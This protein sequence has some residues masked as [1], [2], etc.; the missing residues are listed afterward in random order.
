MDTSPETSRALPA[1]IATAAPPL[2]PPGPPGSMRACVIRRTG[3]REHGMCVNYQV[4]GEHRPGTMA[5]YVVV[6]EQNVARIPRLDPPL[7]WAEAAAFSLA[8][9]TAWRMVVTRARVRAEEWVLV[10]GVGGGVSLAAMQI[11]KLR[12]ARLIVTSASD[13]KLAEARKLGA[14]VTLN[15]RTQPVAPEVRALTGGRGVDVV[16]EN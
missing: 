3:G 2:H 16:V 15:H 1:G 6:P 12:G 10:W 13:A 8:T 11:A 4:I 14:E 7:T 5:E 9:L